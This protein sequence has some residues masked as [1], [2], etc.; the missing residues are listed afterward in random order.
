M[1]RLFPAMLVFVVLFGGL[2]ISLHG[3]SGSAY[4][5]DDEEKRL[6]LRSEEEEKKLDSSG[7]LYRNGEVEAYLAAVVRILVPAGQLEKVPVRVS[8]IRNLSFNAF[9]FANGRI[10]IHSGMLAAMENEAQ[11]AALLGHE[12]S[13][14]LD[15]H[16]LKE[17][18]SAKNKLA[19]SAALG[20]LTGNVILPIG[21]LGALAAISGYSR[22]LETE[23]DTEGLRMMVQAGYEPTE[24]PKL[25]LLL[26]QEV[27]EEKIKE[28]FVFGSHP[29][30]QARIDSYD[31]L[32]KTEYAGKRGRMTNADPFLRGIRPLL[33][34]SAGMELKAGR[35]ERARRETE[36]YLAVA[37]DDARAYFLL[38]E[39]YRQSDKKED[40]AK[41]RE[42]YLKAAA[43]DPGYPD[44]YRSLGLVAYKEH[45]REQARKAFERYLELSPNAPDR[46]HVEEMLKRCLKGESP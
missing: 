26:Q 16:M 45:N 1:K 31:N 25:F 27:Q 7:A 33:L 42:F 20:A 12:I 40:P 10:Y 35:I 38:G 2:P 28:P 15:R 8:I 21:Q 22:D 19:F 32:L 17:I 18:R 14:S 9:T 37:G 11:L 39:T 6:W 36:R 30:L 4:P 44:P 24:A 13:H 41:A 5:V 43:L 23:A 29:K 3:A 46:G 34:D